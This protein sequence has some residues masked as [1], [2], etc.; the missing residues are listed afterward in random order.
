M[1]N[2]FI[3]VM[4]INIFLTLQ[5]VMSPSRMMGV[6]G[7]MGG[8]TNNM[9]GQSPSQNQ[10][11][12]QTHFPTSA[13]GINVNFAQQAGQAGSTQVRGHEECISVWRQ[14]CSQIR[15]KDQFAI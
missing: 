1:F 3:R 6:Q 15:K 12:N 13:G 8:H 10:F 11:M 4:L 5:M 9:V 14:D 2:P 7:M